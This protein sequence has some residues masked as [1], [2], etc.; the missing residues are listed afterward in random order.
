MIAEIV[1]EVPVLPDALLQPGAL[2]R[3]QHGEIL[4]L[5]LRTLCLAH[6]P[7]CTFRLDRQLLRVLG[8]HRFDE[9]HYRRTGQVECALGF[10][11]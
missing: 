9:V 3:R 6:E 7:H 10:E 8:G 11:I 5:A 1:E 2:D 4:P